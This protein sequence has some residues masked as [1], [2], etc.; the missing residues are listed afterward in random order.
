MFRYNERGANSY[1]CKFLLASNSSY[2]K[3]K[4]MCVNYSFKTLRSKY[5]CNIDSYRDK[6]EF[7]SY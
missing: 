6:I 5:G 7:F 3:E 2:F 4:D 1:S